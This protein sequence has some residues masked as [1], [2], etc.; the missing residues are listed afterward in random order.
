MREASMYE[1]FIW[2]KLLDKDI[3]SRSKKGRLDCYIVNNG[4]FLQLSGT[5]CDLGIRVLLLQAVVCGLIRVGGG[6]DFHPADTLHL[7]E[8]DKVGHDNFYGE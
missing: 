7:H 4:N 2:R 6:P 1:S 5:G 8:T 3:Q